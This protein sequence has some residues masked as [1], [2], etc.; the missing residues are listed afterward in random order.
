LSQK[1]SLVRG[2]IVVKPA[3]AGSVGCACRSPNCKWK[4]R[5]RAERAFL[6]MKRSSFRCPRAITG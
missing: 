3:A 4:N 6:T 2:V 5:P 1:N